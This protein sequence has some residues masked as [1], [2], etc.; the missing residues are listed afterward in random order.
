[1]NKMRMTGELMLRRNWIV[2]IGLALVVSG[3]G[4]NNPVPAQ[5]VESVQGIRTQKIEMQ[6]IPDEI[7]A[8]GSVIAV[9]TAQVAAR[10]IGTAIQLSLIHI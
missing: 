10:T 5:K 8:P 3:C 9:N 7:E 4:G 6:P 1:M 2:G